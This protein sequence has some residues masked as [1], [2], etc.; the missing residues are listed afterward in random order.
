MASHPQAVLRLQSLAGNTAV[1]R[2]LGLRPPRVSVQRTLKIGSVDYTKRVTTDG[3]DLEAVVAEV[4]GEAENAAKGK[5]IEDAFGQNREVVRVQLRKWIEHNVG[6]MGLKSHPEFGRK[7]QFREYDDFESLA[8]G[9][10]GWVEAKPGRAAEKALAHEIRDDPAIEQSLNRLLTK[11]SELIWAIDDPSDAGR[12]FNVVNELLASNSVAGAYEEYFKSK[13]KPITRPMLVLDAPEGYDFRTK[14]AVLHDLTEYFGPLRKRSIP[15]VGHG[16]L[17]T[18]TGLDAIA[19]TTGVSGEGHP[20]RDELDR[21]MGKTS[22]TRDEANKGTAFARQYKIPVWASQSYTTA[23]MLKLAEW[24]KATGEEKKHL[25]QAIVAF[26]RREYDHTSIAYHTLHE[27]M[28]VA[29]HFGVPYHP[30]DPFSSLSDAQFDKVVAA[31]FRYL[32]RLVTAVA[33]LH[34]RMAKLTPAVEGLDDL[35]RI[36]K[37]VIGWTTEKEAD[38]AVTDRGEKAACLWEVQALSRQMNTIFV[39]WNR[40]LARLST[41]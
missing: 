33:E 6:A 17:D 32:K 9:V 10:L 19:F 24:A 4:L 1:S 25:A 34:G 7:A 28:D 40:E 15:G 20:I 31:A 18:E 22:S 27:V 41:V 36:A 16:L 11:L 35:E 37:E 14:V 29:H 21:G 2:V 8:R 39:S 30:L 38:L 12:S 5:D 26:W 23:R 13:G 3:E